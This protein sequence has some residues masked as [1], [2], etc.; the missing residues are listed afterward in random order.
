MKRLCIIVSLLGVL[1]SSCA[2]F[3]PVTAEYYDSNQ[4]ITIVTK[5]LTITPIVEIQYVHG[6]AMDVKKVIEAPNG[7]IWASL[8]LSI[9]SSSEGIK[10]YDLNEIVLITTNGNTLIPLLAKKLPKTSSTISKSYNSTISP[11]IWELKKGNQEFAIF[12]DVDLDDTPVFIKIGESKPI[13]LN[14]PA[15]EYKKKPIIIAS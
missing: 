4:E 8:I 14:I 6:I 10:K 13:D 11:F 7:H 15:E 1:F 12:Y 2:T 3:N 9:S 5:S